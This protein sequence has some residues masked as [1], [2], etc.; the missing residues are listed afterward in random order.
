MFDTDRLQSVTDLCGIFVIGVDTGVG[1]TYIGGAIIQNLCG[2]W[3][4]CRSMQT[5]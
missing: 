5:G 2:T 4:L 1:K 3:S